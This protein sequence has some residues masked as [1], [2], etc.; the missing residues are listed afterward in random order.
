MDGWKY[1][2]VTHWRKRG[3]DSQ[4]GALLREKSNNSVAL[5]N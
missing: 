4:H 2:H 3:S 1:V 5:H